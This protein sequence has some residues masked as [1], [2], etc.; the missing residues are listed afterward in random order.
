MP[1]PQDEPNRAPQDEPKGPAQPQDPAPAEA[2][3]TS[4]RAFLA[5]LALGLAA[6]AAGVAAWEAV[7]SGAA[8]AP[9]PARPRGQ[10]PQAGAHGRASW[11]SEENSRPGS[12]SWAISGYAIPGALDAYS[13]S[14]SA[15]VGDV[16]RL[17]VSCT[18]PSFHVEA[19]RMGYYGGVGARMLWRSA[20]L[21]ATPQPPSTFTPGTNMVECNWQ[22]SLAL[23]VGRDWPEGAYLLKITDSAGQ[24]RYVPLVV[25]N[26]KSR[27][28]LV[29][30]HS[31]CTWQAYNW[32][33]GYSLYYGP[34][35]HDFFNRSRVVSFDRPYASQWAFG[36]ADFVGN[37]LPLVMLVEKLGLDVTYWTDVDFALRPQLL[38]NHKA[39]L[40][41]G[42][43]EYWTPGM[44]EAALAARDAGVNFAFFGANAC[45]R[46]IRLDPSP[47]GPARRQV[48]YKVPTEDPLY[49]KD[50]AL[51]TANFPDPPVPRP[52]SLLI[53]P[54][55]QS[56]GVLADMVIS[57]ASSWV[58]AGT[59]L[60]AGDRIP[61]VVGSE[62]DGLDPAVAGP[63]NI[64]V[65]AHS[66]VVAQGRPGF[67]D[68]TWYT[69]GHMGG[70]FASGTN[71]WV[72]RLGDYSGK[73]PPGL[74]P[75][76]VPGVTAP[77]TKM[78][79]NILAVLGAGPA[80]ASH[81]SLGNWSPLYPGPAPA[82]TASNYRTYWPA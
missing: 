50:N 55:Y 58:L 11:V 27:A 8:P 17:F 67:S 9:R 68:M 2:R 76:A 12:P 48:C 37:E 71:L 16:V 79:E 54:M 21:P 49:G 53:G 44:F 81:P 64:D 32:W 28:A 22:P 6:P 30:Q 70:V 15:Q 72:N 46:R 66:P 19:Y 23:T 20:T 39:L 80:G 7:R 31:V 75:A 60:A 24:Q 69:Q 63:R 51:V 77:L 82:A 13:D 38:T 42:H 18:A 26:D 62:Y 1:A 56:Y 43:D 29:V 61:K 41:L 36:A 73:F 59:G 14:V 35:G 33:G 25:R 45:F 34:P 47:L 57:D 10:R 78:T 65:I 74:V 3:P 5:R 40:S 52:E 4:R